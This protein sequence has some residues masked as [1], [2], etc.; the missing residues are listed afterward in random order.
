[1]TAKLRTKFIEEGSKVVIVP[2]ERSLMELFRGLVQREP[3]EWP[4]LHPSDRGT[5]ISL[6]RLKGTRDLNLIGGDTGGGY[7][8]DSKQPVTMIEAAGALTIAARMGSRFIPMRNFS[9]I[10]KETSEPTFAWITEGNAPSEGSPLFG[11]FTPTIKTGMISV[12]YSGLLSS[13]SGGLVDRTLAASFFKSIGRGVDAAVFHG[14]G[15]DGE[16][17]GIEATPDVDTDTGGSYAIADAAAQLG[18]VETG[19]ADTSTL[20]WCMDPAT[21]ELLRQRPKVAA[22][23]R[24]LFEDGK[25][26]DRPAYVSTGI[27]AGAIFCGSFS[28]VL[29]LV[30]EIE[31]V[32]NPF[33]QS[34]KHVRELVGFWHGDIAIGHPGYFSVRTSVT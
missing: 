31:V 8:K 9:P 14:S 11:L 18:A 17:R 28:D 26:L 27:G 30:R 34:K 24:M 33:S 2:P 32:Y 1:M 21:A 4:E 25:I 23:E 15:I 29:V 10:P 13:A 7:L 16:P 6:V 20:T 3:P 12:D 22:G 19:N 5:G